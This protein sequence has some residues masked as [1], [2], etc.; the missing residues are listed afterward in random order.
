MQVARV[1]PSVQLVSR[2]TRDL[3]AQDNK[4]WIIKLHAQLYGILSPLI[5]KPVLLRQSGG[6]RPIGLPI[7]PDYKRGVECDV[8]PFRLTFACI[9][10]RGKQIG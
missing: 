5:E 7:G 10:G 3:V 2:L 9:S 6:R 8:G 1:M 4:L